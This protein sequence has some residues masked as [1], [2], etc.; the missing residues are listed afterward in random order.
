MAYL[1]NHLLDPFYM[2]FIIYCMTL[3]R[4]VLLEKLLYKGFGRQ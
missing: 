4:R 3:W 2:T 1:H